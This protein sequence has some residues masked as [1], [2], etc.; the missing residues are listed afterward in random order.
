MITDSFTTLSEEFKKRNAT[1]TT[2]TPQQRRILIAQDVLDQL[3][4]EKITACC[5]QWADIYL[6][7]EVAVNSQI[8][9]ILE[10]EGVSCE[11]CALGAMTLSEIRQM[12]NLT[13]ND[14]LK[15]SDA[16]AYYIS[17]PHDDVE[18][19]LE[20]YFE[21]YQLV[22]IELAFERGDGAYLIDE[23]LDKDNYD[24]GCIVWTQER[25]AAVDFGHR[26][27]NNADRLIMIMTNIVKNNGTFVP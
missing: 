13:V 8:C 5:G 10:T 15:R 2:A 22:L 7:K 21:K 27:D 20:D 19:R 24:E 9:S 3:K 25:S 11:A 4:A 26:Y 23:G 14:V 18:K 12:D 17:L 16:T 6:P 1:F